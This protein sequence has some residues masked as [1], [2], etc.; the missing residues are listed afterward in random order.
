M[1]TIIR[2]SIVLISLCALVLPALNAQPV[3]GRASERSANASSSKVTR[4][5][6]KNP[7]GTTTDVTE[8][9]NLAD[10]SIESGDNELVVSTDDGSVITINPNSSVVVGASTDGGTQVTVV[11]GSVIASSQGA[12]VNVSTAAG[13]FTTTGGNVFVTQ[14]STDG[15][16][17][18]VSA[19][20]AEG[21]DVTLTTTDGATSTVDVG[22]QTVIQGQSGRAPQVQ[23]TPAPTQIVA[24]INDR[25][26]S[27]VSVAVQVVTPTDTI[28]QTDTSESEETETQETET[29]STD[30][31]AETTETETVTPDAVEQVVIDIPVDNVE[32]ASNPG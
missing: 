21:S 13:T 2:K 32:V 24:V 18:V 3:P 1:K 4:V 25:A 31:V 26:S 28:A 14:S 5:L 27:S 10:G 16:N 17:Y 22:T 15:E 30:D 23:S 29:E 12:P 7:D 9:Y 8:E 6:Q 20:N 19:V 11:N